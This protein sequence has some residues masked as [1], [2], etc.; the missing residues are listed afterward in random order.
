MHKGK[1]IKITAGFSTEIL[2]A[3][4]SCSKVFQALKENNFSPRIL[5]PAKLSLRTDGRIKL[6]MVSRHKT[7]Y[8]HQAT[9]IEEPARKSTHKRQKQTKS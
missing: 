6:S 1:C 5:N 7:I 9:T 4:R 2:K 3:R 8:Y